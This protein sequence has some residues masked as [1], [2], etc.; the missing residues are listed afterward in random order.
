MW[1]VISSLNGTFICVRRKIASETIPGSNAFVFL[2]A[3]VRWAI[4][5]ELDIARGEVFCAGSI[6]H[7]PSIFRKR[8]TVFVKCKG[9][10]KERWRVHSHYIKFVCESNKEYIETKDIHFH[11]VQLCYLFPYYLPTLPKKGQKQ[12]RETTR[13][14]YTCTHIR[15][16]DL[17]WKVFGPTGS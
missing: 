5:M 3:C 15:R 14:Y 6:F 16:G 12:Q 2:C 4:E 7:S 17:P 10:K 11:T 1:N 8:K 13:A 9:R